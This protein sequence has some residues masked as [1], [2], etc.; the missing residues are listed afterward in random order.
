[1]RE[2]RAERV[3]EPFGRRAA[4]AAAR[5]VRDPERLALRER[6]LVE[7]GVAEVVHDDGDPLALALLRAA[8]GSAVVFPAPRKPETIWTG[9]RAPQPRRLRTASASSVNSGTVRSQLMHL[10]VMLWP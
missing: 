6:D 8:R 2:D 4:D 5:D 3:H 10:S 1:M 7:R 9:T